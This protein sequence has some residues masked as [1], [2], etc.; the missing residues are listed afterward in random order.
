MRSRY[1]AFAEQNADYLLATWHPEH[2]PSELHFA[3]EL[4]WLGLQILHCEQGQPGDQQG[5]VEFIARA[6]HPAQ[7]AHRQQERSYFSFSDGRWWYC[8]GTVIEA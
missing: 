7:P 6:K 1:T 4:R 8:T 5:V 3:P 2:R